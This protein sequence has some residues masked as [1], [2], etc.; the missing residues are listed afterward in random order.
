MIITSFK[1]L[2]NKINNDL[3][4]FCLEFANE[5]KN[6]AKMKKRPKKILFNFDGK[7]WAKSLGGGTEIQFYIDMERKNKNKIAYGLGFNM[8]HCYGKNE[9]TPSEYMRPFCD[10]FLKL[11][12][13]NHNS[14]K[15]D[16]IYG[17]E[18][19]MKNPQ[20]GKFV[21]YGKFITLNNNEL[22]DSD[23][24]QILIDLQ[25]SL[26]DIYKQVF[27]LRNQIE[28]NIKKKLI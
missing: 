13:N 12:E 24:K 21:L 18:E 15:F 27:S 19:L 1:E 2:I 6:L 4:N 14:W 26:F 20:D 9:M 7:D 16:W 28:E 8:Q 22:S 11:Y 3:G 10:A 25:G 23:Y 5:R 17:N